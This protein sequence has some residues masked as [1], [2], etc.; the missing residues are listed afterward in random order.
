[1]Y[2]VNVAIPV[3]QSVEAAWDLKYWLLSFYLLIGV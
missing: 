1:M 3:F 2:G